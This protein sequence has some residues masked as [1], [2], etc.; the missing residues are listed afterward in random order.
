MFEALALRKEE[1]QRRE[2]A[3]R[4][5]V[6]DLDSSQRKIYY[7]RVMKAIRDPDTFAVLNYFFIAGLHHF[8]LGRYVRGLTN[9]AILVVGILLWTAGYPGYWLILVVVLIEL[10]ALFRSEVI[11]QDYILSS[12]RIVSICSCC[13]SER[14]RSSALISCRYCLLLPRRSFLSY[15]GPDLLIMP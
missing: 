13:S 4:L 10:M 15:P 11:V 5:R 8:Y 6:V 2:E 3:L 9:L 14:P 1:V 7:D 12:V